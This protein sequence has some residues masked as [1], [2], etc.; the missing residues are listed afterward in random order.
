MII[1]E[2]EAVPLV[3]DLINLERVILEALLAD[4]LTEE[5]V[6][7]GRAV[8]NRRISCSYL[9]R[10]RA[11]AA[12]T[13]D[14]QPAIAGELLPRKCTAGELGGCGRIVNRQREIGKVALTFLSS[15]QRRE[16]PLGLRSCRPT[17]EIEEPESAVLAIVD[18]GNVNRT[19][20]SKAILISVVP[21]KVFLE[22]VS[23]LKVVSRIKFIGTSMKLIGARANC[24][25]YDAPLLIP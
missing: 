10:N 9:C 7:Y 2:A 3:Q 15:R 18:V 13:N 11:D 19:A 23:G 24:K 16:A 20:Q 21:R 17:V 1:S 4:A 12:G 6:R 8:G 14:V 5:I 22:K 25:A